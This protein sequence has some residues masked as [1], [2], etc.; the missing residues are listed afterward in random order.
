MH[1]QQIKQDSQ[2]TGAVEVKLMVVDIGQPT[3]EEEGVYKPRQKNAT[4]N[5]TLHT[6]DIR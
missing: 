6:H 1:I 4:Y 5:T 3:G 2:Q